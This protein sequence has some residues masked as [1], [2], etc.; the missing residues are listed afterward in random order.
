MWL[1]NFWEIMTRLGWYCTLDQ[2]KA[3]VDVENL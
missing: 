3:Q 2:H 1:M